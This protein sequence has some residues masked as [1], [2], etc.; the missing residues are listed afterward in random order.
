MPTPLTA[1]PSAPVSSRSAP[2]AS[3]EPALPLPVHRALAV[4]RI[5]TGAIFLWAFVDK[6][7]G[8]GYATAS[9]NSW[10]NG[11]S[12]ASG[13]L[14]GV[15]AGPLE[16]VFRS[17]AGQTWVDW[18]YM[19]GMLGIGAALVAGVALRLTALAGGL[20]LLTLWIAEWPPA[21]HLSDGTP[22]MSPNPLVD[23]HVVYLVALVVLAL[24]SAGRTWGLG[25]RW[26]RLPLVARH[27]WLR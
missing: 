26:A 15:S 20:M 3:F 13:Y 1:E 23:Q 21:R 17:M 14:S 24:C 5:A 11:G 4:L 22:S 7:F 8:L 6:T 10:L 12:P 18:A 9:Q 16:S 19:A 25:G 2:S 27:P